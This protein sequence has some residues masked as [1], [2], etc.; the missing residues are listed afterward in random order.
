MSKPLKSTGFIGPKDKTMTRLSRVAEITAIGGLMVSTVI[1][2]T[3]IT[4]GVA[5]AGVVDGIVGN[6]DS[7]FTIALILGLFF[8]G[9]GGL[10]LVPFNTRRHRN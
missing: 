8:I 9:V 4:V 3:A 7:V 2:L 1:A 5:H 6:E 10:S